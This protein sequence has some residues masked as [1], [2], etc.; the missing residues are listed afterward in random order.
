MLA[1]IAPVIQFP[2]YIL[3]ICVTVS[4]LSLIIYGSKTIKSFACCALGFIWCAIFANSY[5]SWQ[6]NSHMIPKDQHIVAKITAVSTKGADRYSLNVVTSS[7]NGQAVS[8]KVRLSWYQGYSQNLSPPRVLAVGDKLEFIARLKPVNGLH[9]KAGFDYQRWLVANRIQATGYIKKVIQH[10]SQPSWR[11]TRQQISKNNV[12]PYAFGGVL[13]AL[14]TGDRQLVK[15]GDWQVMQSTGTAHLM[16][17]SGLHLGLIFSWLWL[18]FKLLFKLGV[19][20]GVLAQS[21][22]Q[23]RPLWFRQHNINQLAIYVAWLG[24]AFF[25]WYSG[26]NIATVRAMIML[27]VFIACYLMAKRMANLTRFLLALNCVLLVDPLAPLSLGFWLSFSAVAIILFAVHVFNLSAKDLSPTSSLWQKARCYFWDFVKLQ[28]VLSLALLPIQWLTLEISSPV[29]VL[30]NFIAIPWMSL[31]V[32]PLTLAAEVCMTLFTPLATFLLT[33]ANA[34]MQ[35]LWWVLVSFSDLQ[36]Q[37]ALSDNLGVW[38]IFALTLIVCLLPLQIK[39]KQLSLLLSGLVILVPVPAPRWQVDIMDV[40]QGLSLVF[41]QGNQAVL[42]DTGAN[43]P[44][45]N[46]FEVAVKPY[47]ITQGFNLQSIVISHDDN[48]HAGGLKHV[49]KNYPKASVFTPESTTCVEGQTF[50]WLNLTWQVLHPPLDWVANTYHGKEKIK[51]NNLSCVILMSTPHHK[52]L[53][54]GDIES[55][56]EQRL[57]NKYA[58]ELRSIDLSIVAHHGSATSSTPL[59]VEHVQAQHWFVSRGAYNRFN[60]PNEG[61]VERLLRSGQLW[62]TARHG[63]I[64]ISIEQEKL[65]INKHIDNWYTP[66]WARSIHKDLNLSAD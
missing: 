29:S 65:A 9:N 40:G 38:L 14:A 47:L 10:I 52:I 21:T 42:Y 48:D 54:T 60:H 64:T 36:W 50:N 56:V 5:L 27:S 33:L 8:A 16:A 58:N 37:P 34:C 28:I 51:D 22:I 6:V 31:T 26:S 32:I 43:Y 20:I 59:F 12:E 24:T 18:V 2:Y 66:W 63:Q 55:H 17:I 46:L 39:V 15:P 13:F 25:T 7:I 53:L 23:R 62:D 49:Q 61:V 19:A 41:S 44:G 35:P 1:N 11:Y 3:V 57:I 45:F 30:A 4:L